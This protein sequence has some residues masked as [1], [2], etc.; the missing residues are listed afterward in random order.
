[1]TNWDP[2]APKAGERAPDLELL[3]EAGRLVRLSDFARRK[4]LLVLVFAGVDDPE[5]LQLLRDYRDVTLAMHKAGV[6]IC[7]IGPADPAALRY[8]RSERGLGFPVLGDPGGTALSRWG[9]LERTG[10]FL[11]GRGLVVRQRA[12][13]TRA[14]AD[15]MVTFV[16]RGGARTRSNLPER[17][18]TFFHAL[19]HAFGLARPA[20]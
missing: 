6:S 19:Q 17:V 11:L 10:L 20:R 14:P 2:R 7:A 13:G 8:M 16:K 15:A 9:M 3:D 5:G 1:M 18:A 4:A 12:A